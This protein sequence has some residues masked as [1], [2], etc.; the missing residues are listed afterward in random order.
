MNIYHAENGK[1]SEQ[2]FRSAIEDSNQTITFLGLGLIINMPLLEE[3]FK[4]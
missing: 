4:I 1:C 3:K 2:T